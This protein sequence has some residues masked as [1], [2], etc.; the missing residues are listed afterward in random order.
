MENN[1]PLSPINFFRNMDS[2]ALNIRA[3]LTEGIAFGI[4]RHDLFDG[5][6]QDINKIFINE[7]N[8]RRFIKEKNLEIEFEQFSKM[9]S[10]E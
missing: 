6:I 2:R 1:E 7:L 8:L 4:L 3:S 5:C 10:F 9:G